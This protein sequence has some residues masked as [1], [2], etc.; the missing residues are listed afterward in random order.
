MFD[1]NL[2]LKF[3]NFNTTFK[4]FFYIWYLLAHEWQ[5]F[6]FCHRQRVVSAVKRKAAWLVLWWVWQKLSF[7]AWFKVECE[8]IYICMYT[9]VVVLL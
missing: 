2:L 6:S 3:K 4:P 7:T 1:L 8:H 5:I 9:S